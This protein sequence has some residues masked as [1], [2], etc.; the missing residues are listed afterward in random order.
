MERSQDLDPH[1]VQRAAERLWRQRWPEKVGHQFGVKWALEVASYSDIQDLLA[2][3]AEEG[4]LVER[5]EQDRPGFI[6]DWADDFQGLDDERC[7][8]GF[9][10]GVAQVL[11]AVRDQVEAEEQ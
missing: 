4:D 9:A 1:A 6:E 8:R 3:S 11:D 5:L 10:D 2:L 7:W